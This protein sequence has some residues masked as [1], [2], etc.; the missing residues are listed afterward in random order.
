MLTGQFVEHALTDQTTEIIAHLACSVGTRRSPQQVPNEG[1]QRV[2][3]HPVGEGAHGAQGGQQGHDAR[4]AQAQA[5]GPLPLMDRGEDQLLK[6]GRRQG[7]VLRDP[8]QREQTSIDLSTDLPEIVEVLEAALD[9]EVIRV[10]DG[11]FGSQRSVFFERLFDATMLVLDVQAGGDPMV[12]HAG[13]EAAGRGAN[14]LPVKQHWHAIGAAQIQVL[15]DHLLEK[16][17]AMERAVEDLREADFHLE[18]REAWSIAGG[19]VLRE[20]GHRQPAEPPRKESLNVLSREAIGQRLD[21]LGIPA[22]GNPVVERGEG[23]P[24]RAQLALQPFM[25]IETELH[26]KGGIGA[27]L[28]E[29]RAP[30]WVQDREIVVGDTDP[31]SVVR[32]VDVPAGALMR[33]PE[34]VGFLLSDPDEDD[35]LRLLEAGMVPLGHL[36]LA[37]PLRE[38]NHRRSHP[39]RELLDPPSIALRDVPQQFGGGDGVAAMSAE[40]G[41]QLLGRLQG[42]EVPIEVQAVH[43]V[44][45]QGDMVF[46]KLSDVGH[47]LLRGVGIPEEI[48]PNGRPWEEVTSLTGVCC[49]SSV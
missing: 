23:Q 49:Y 30:L 40:E 11:G 36:V 47:A 16:L 1:P 3:G 32:E 17:P 27:D 37:L 8:L 15:P 42:G 28:Q 9:P 4:I 45:F 31:L 25:A 21:G 2:I 44:N 6:T 22:T 19:N 13:A 7:T 24:A 20:H 33:G 26:G 43:A 34:G 46:D 5:W 48:A 29:R 39:T 14:Q 35:A 41:H 12:N 38:L 18:Q 10:I